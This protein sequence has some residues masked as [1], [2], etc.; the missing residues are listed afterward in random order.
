MKIRNVIPLFLFSALVLLLGGCGS[1]DKSGAQNEQASGL[2]VG[3]KALSEHY[4]EVNFDGTVKQENLDAFQ[5]SISSS[6][7]DTLAINKVTLVDNGKSVLLQ[8]G[9]QKPTRYSLSVAPA[10]ASPRNKIGALATAS[11]AD[12]TLDF[13]G[14]SITEPYVSSAIALGNNEVLVTFSEVMDKA[15]VEKIANYRIVAIDENQS[16]REDVG[17]LVISGAVLEDVKSANRVRLTTSQQYDFEYTLIVT[18]VISSPG[19]KLINP[20]LSNANFFGIAKDDT[21]PPKLLNGASTG[22]NTLLLYFSEPL[23]DSAESQLNY[24]VCAMEFDADGNCPAGSELNIL[25]AA[26]KEHNT[27]VELT[28]EP[29]QAG[30]EYY[31]KVA[32]IT[33]QAVPAPGNLMETTVTKY[34]TAEA[35]VNSSEKPHVVGAISTSNTSVIVSFSTAM[36]SSALSAS[37]Y[38]FTQENI[39]PEVGTI[40]VRSVQW[41]DGTRTAVEVETSPQNEVTYRVTVVNV[42]DYFGNPMDSKR[43]ILSGVLYDPISMTFAGT[44]PSYEELVLGAGDWQW[45]DVNENGEVDAGDLVKVGDKSIVLTNI[46]MSTSESGAAVV[47]NWLDNGDGIL[48]E[49][50]TVMGLIDSDMMRL[51]LTQLEPIHYGVIE[52]ALLQAGIALP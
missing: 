45:T 40:A 52:Q 16:P 46:S 5:F 42:R 24:L 41:T 25:N 17:D 32:N 21:T 13:N 39:N 35:V 2:P 43:E 18:N 38:L 44:P 28:T 36:G 27:M 22:V 30:V 29:Q 50:D 10:G 37:H 12:I 31:I 3:A 34:T 47:D 4:V 33:D 19:S 20:M 1:G 48:G 51:P 6:S 23:N 11:S 15:S 14:S 49:G 8:T 26:L 9:A 7:G